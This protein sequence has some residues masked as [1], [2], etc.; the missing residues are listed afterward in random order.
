MVIGLMN[1]PYTRLRTEEEELM[2]DAGQMDG[3]D[4]ER[5]RILDDLY[6]LRAFYASNGMWER[7]TTVDLI[8][9]KVTT[10]FAEDEEGEKK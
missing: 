4:M 3:R 2:F 7:A 8:I 6:Q 1:S 9:N 10:P 5:K